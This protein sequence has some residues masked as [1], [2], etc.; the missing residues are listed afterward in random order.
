M[1]TKE[2]T[3][4]EFSQLA[5]TFSTACKKTVTQSKAASYTAPL[6]TA[7]FVVLTVGPKIT[8]NAWN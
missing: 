8:A 3:P 1:K 7:A 2:S 5:K 4:N 6:L